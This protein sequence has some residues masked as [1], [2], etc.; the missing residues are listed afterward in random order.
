MNDIQ[1]GRLYK[2]EGRG[3]QY[4]IPFKVS[5]EYVAIPNS[6]NN[7]IAV[8]YYDIKYPESVKIL[9]LEWFNQSFS[10][11]EQRISSLDT[12]TKID[13]LDVLLFPSLL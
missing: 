12:S 2:N 13:I 10:L 3:Q 9:I 1:L 7:R 8:R 4:V 5:E 6:S 11:V